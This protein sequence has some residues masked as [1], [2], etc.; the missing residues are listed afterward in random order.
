MTSL[1]A[2][3][4]NRDQAAFQ[5]QLSTSILTDVN[6]RDWLGRT[7]L[8]LAC[9]ASARPAT[10]YVRM[11]LAHRAIDVNMQDV[12]SHW[13]ALHRALYNGNIASAYVMAFSHD[14]SQL[15]AFPSILLLQKDD[16]DTSL[17]DFEGYRAFDVY[18]T[19]VEETMPSKCNTL[20]GLELYTWGSNRYVRCIWLAIFPPTFSRSN[21]V[22]P[23]NASLG[24][25][26]TDDRTHP[27]QVVLRHHEVGEGTKARNDISFTL[28]PAIVR[29]VQMSRLHT[30]MGCPPYSKS[31]IRVGEIP[32]L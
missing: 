16:I 11:L 31:P 2:Y 19:T 15:T 12:E 21:H 4:H 17:K 1:H 9:A 14:N 6:A 32:A 8:H 3:F 23:R 5:R 22:D 28:Q 29:D 24:H 7:V 20:S 27:E 26:D 10:E 18:N 25:G 13:T 30:G